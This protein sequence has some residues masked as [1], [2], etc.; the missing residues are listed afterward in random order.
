MKKMLRH[1]Y[2]CDSLAE[3]EK[4][5]IELE[6]AGISTPQI[7]VL[8]E[9]HQELERH[10][11]LHEVMDLMKSDVVHRMKIGA[12]IGIPVCLSVLL[13]AYFS[14]LTETVG[15]LPFLFLAFALLGFCTWEGGL[16]GIQLPN[17]RFRRF[18]DDIKMGKHIFFVDVSA[19]QEAILA[20]SIHKHP[21]VRSA[22]L[23]LSTPNWIINM[24][25]LG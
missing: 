7:H 3:L 22:G 6:H 5:E 12:M 24:Q 11:Q 20:N 2:I 4:L 8:S 25:K 21:E 15:W 16:L 10:N 23:G 18:A 17:R 19:K 13:Y 9:D 14:D 1:Y